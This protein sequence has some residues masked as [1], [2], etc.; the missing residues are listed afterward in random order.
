[1]PTSGFQ[2]S[3]QLATP[4]THSRWSLK[5]TTSPRNGI[6]RAV[7]TDTYMRWTGPVKTPR[8]SCAMSLLDS[9]GNRLVRC[10]QLPLASLMRGADSGHPLNL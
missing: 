2:Q 4:P 10:C 5:G 7:S 8:R 1:M 9:S 3:T 6:S